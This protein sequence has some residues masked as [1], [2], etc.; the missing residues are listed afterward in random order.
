MD[1]TQGEITFL[2]AA[3]D[4]CFYAISHLTHVVDMGSETKNGFKTELLP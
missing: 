1:R 3:M 2:E 4:F